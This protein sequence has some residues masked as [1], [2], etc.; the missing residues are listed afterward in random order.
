MKE[1]SST[2]W[3]LIKDLFVC[4]PE[5]LLAWKVHGGARGLTAMGLKY[6]LINGNKEIKCSCV[7]GEISGTALHS[8]K[9][10]LKKLPGHSEVI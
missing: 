1:Y 3:C 10:R 7:P 6:R 8:P 2:A 9:T 4:A 5:E